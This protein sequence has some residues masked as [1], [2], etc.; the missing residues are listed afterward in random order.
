VTQHNVTDAET[1][2]RWHS[3]YEWFNWPGVWSSF[4][5]V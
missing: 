5:R 2:V 4:I 1:T 3:Y